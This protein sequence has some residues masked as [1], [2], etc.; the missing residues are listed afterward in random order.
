MNDDVTHPF[1]D[2]MMQTWQGWIDEV[3]EKYG[4]LLD[5]G[6]YSIDWGSSWKTN[7]EEKAV[8][9]DGTNEEVYGVSGNNED[10]K[11]DGN[12]DAAN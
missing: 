3:N 5:N 10:Q 8:L 7:E 11:G 2:D 9:T 6:L 4:D 1:V 12:D